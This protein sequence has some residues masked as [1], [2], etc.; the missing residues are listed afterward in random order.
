MGHCRGH[1][2][3]LLLGPFARQADCPLQADR[4]TLPSARKDVE[5]PNLLRALSSGGSPT[6]Q[7]CGP[8][9]ARDPNS[10]FLNQT[11]RTR[12]APTSCWLRWAHLI[13][14]GLPGARPRDTSSLGPVS[15]V[16]RGALSSEGVVFHPGA[17]WPVLVDES[18]PILCM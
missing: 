11:L 18:L 13:P 1:C 12:A 17:S 9:L 2:N 6:S 16:V 14:P 3:I 8:E 15:P 4:C 5:C 10:L 7:Q